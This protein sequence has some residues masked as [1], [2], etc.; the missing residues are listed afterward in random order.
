MKNGK[1]LFKYILL[2]IIGITLI[3]LGCTNTIDSFWSGMGS[4]LILVS[5][6]RLF[7]LYRYNSS[8]E[9]KERVEIE[10]SDERNKFIR[11]KAWAWTGYLFVIIVSIAVIVLRI[12]GHELLSIA[13]GY[14]VCFIVLIYWISFFILKRKY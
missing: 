12:M 8:A 14:A 6:L 11:N 4:A 3:V 5:A 9:Y 10:L 1:M 2:V 13:F 7:N